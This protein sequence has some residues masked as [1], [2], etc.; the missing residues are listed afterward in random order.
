[1][2]RLIFA[3]ILLPLLFAC[4]TP[5]Q[6]KGF[7]GGWTDS[8]ISENT[9]KISFKGNASTKQERV[10]ELALLRA[11]DL[12]LNNG[13]KYFILMSDKGSTK[14]SYSVIGNNIYEDA[15]H[16]AVILIKMTNYNTESALDA[17]SVKRNISAKYGIKK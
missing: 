8:Q 16:T 11:A 12:T 9:F 17:A 6:K 7:R 10:E 13:Y 5:Y 15:E 3:I 14:M 1:M 4:A 2:K